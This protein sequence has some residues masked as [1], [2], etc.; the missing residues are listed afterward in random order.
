MRK[1]QHLL[2]ITAAV[3]VVFCLASCNYQIPNPIIGTYS[4]K[5]EGSTYDSAALCLNKDGSFVFVQI[6]PNTAKTIRLEG[7]YTYSLRAF[8]FTAADGSITLEVKT[9]IPNGV[10]NTF[11]KE[12]SNYF[13][14]DWKCDKDSGPQS[15]TL[16]T[17][18]N[19]ISSIYEFVYSA[20]EASL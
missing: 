2:I 8:N 3:L 14:Y 19:D 4:L 12:G 13:L 11:L 7:T 16:A 18:T 5:A 15:I 20:T 9:P 10:Q 1:A 6:I 17:N